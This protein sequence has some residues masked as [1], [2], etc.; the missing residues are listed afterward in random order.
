MSTIVTRAGKGSP[1]TNTEVDANFTNL[2]DDKLENVSEDTTPQLGGV[3]DTNGN[4][5]EFG[6]STGA[7]VNRL[8]FG[9]SDDLVIYHDGTHSYVT[10]NGT[11]NLRLKGFNVQIVSSGNETMGLFKPNEG[12]SLWYDNAKKIETTSSGVD[13]TGTLVSDNAQFGTGG[14]NTDFSVELLADSGGGFAEIGRIKLIRSNYD[15]TGVAASIDFH[16]GGGAEDGAIYFSTNS[17]TSG[18][19]TK[20][21]LGITDNGPVEFYEDTGTT[22][23]LTW[24]ASAEELQFKDNVKAEFGD[25]GDL[26]IYHNGTNT[27]LS[28]SEGHLYLTNNSND[29][30]IKILTDD[31]SGGTADYIVA[32]GSTGEVQLYHYGSEKLAT[33]STGI[34]VT[35]TVTADGLTVDGDIAINDTTP[36]ITITDTD[37]ATTGFITATGSSVRF[38]SSTSDNCI[39]YSNNLSRLNINSGG[40]ISFYDDSGSSQD[41]YWDASTSRLGLGTTSPD[42]VLH[43]ENGATS[44]TWTPNGR[45][46]AIIEGNNFSGTTLSIIGK[47]TGYSGI[48][49]GDE[50]FET[51]GQINYDHTAGAMRFAT[52]GAEKV[53]IDSSGNVGIGTTSPYVKFHAVNGADSDVILRVDGTDVN[54]EY[55]ALG[56]QSGLGVLRA[57]GIGSTSTG[58]R[59]DVANAGAESEAARI[60]SDGILLVGRTSFGFGGSGHAIRPTLSAVF[61]NDGGAAVIANRNTSDG[62][63]VDFRKDGGSVGSIGVKGS[64]TYFGSSDVGLYANGS[65]NNILPF[66][67]ATT[68]YRDAG[69]DVG[70]SNY[71]FK[72]LYLS[73]G[74][75]LGG[76]GSANLLDDYEE[77]TW[78]PVLSDAATGGNTGTFTNNGCLYTKIGNIVSLYI[79]ISAIS[80]T[81]MTSGNVFY[82]QGLPFVTQSINRWIGSAETRDITSSGYLSLNS[83][84]N[85][86]YM[87]LSDTSSFSLRTVSHITSGSGLVYG[88]LVYR[89]NS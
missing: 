69:I 44:Y 6:D 28:N 41:F 66:S 53:R 89:T 51:D 7:E 21:R 85:A 10:D 23:K 71:R 58:L 4:N 81:G 3:L 19:N 68:N 43:V 12:A 82:I 52:R 31:G 17:G 20:H 48:F 33:K 79:N 64:H 36:T 29:K 75:Y 80:T 14:V 65:G 67:T 26:L 63:I 78:T 27:F 1:L 77:G 74:V 2:N 30:D 45:T 59:F 54:S 60:N 73:G 56:I 8:K 47:S 55:L 11:G 18:D 22:A 38:G 13:V 72:N 34:D 15:P 9:A 35:G 70:N 5:I 25:G 42:T 24:D 88:T 86:S 32:D 61:N 39:L 50:A 40:D 37:G 57:G 83:G 62:T 46:A 87:R 49:F 76:T 84:G 16:R